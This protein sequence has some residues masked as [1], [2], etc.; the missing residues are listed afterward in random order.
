MFNVY[1]LA[2]GQ[3]RFK[4][5]LTLDCAIEFARAVLILGGEITSIISVKDD[6]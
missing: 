1:Y 3:S 5:Y 2:E 4:K 6:E